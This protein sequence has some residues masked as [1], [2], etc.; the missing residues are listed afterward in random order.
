MPKT[1]KTEIIGYKFNEL[2]NEIKTRLY[3]EDHEF[4]YT[5]DFEPLEEEFRALLIEYFGADPETLEVY[6][7][8]SYSQGSGACCVGDLDVETVLEKRVG[9]YFTKVLELIESRKVVI[10]AITIV[11]CG[12][13]NFYC[14]ENTCRVEIDYVDDPTLVDE[15]PVEEAEELEAMLTN[16]IREEL[17]T[18]YS[19]LQ[20]H[21]E[22]ST[23]FEAY[24]ETMNNSDAVYTEEGQVVDPAFIRS[25]DV[26]DGYQLKLDFEDQG[27]YNFT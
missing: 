24:C 12:P 26:Y 5:V 13:S 9:S 4:S 15:W 14:H 8:V 22:D 19:K 10:D 23:S 25:A 6:S 11:R 3:D 18:F 21:Y 16:A 2:S 17:C 27:D 1:Y 20:D 7:D